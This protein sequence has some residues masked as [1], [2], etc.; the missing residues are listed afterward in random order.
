MQGVKKYLLSKAEHLLIAVIWIIVFILPVLIIGYSGRNDWERVFAIWKRLIPFLIL[1][2]LNHYLLVPFL[3]F[4][5][6]KV[7]YFLVSTIL[8][9]LLSANEFF[10]PKPQISV[11]QKQGRELGFERNDRH[12]P[13]SFRRREALPNNKFPQENLKRI[14]ANHPPGHWPPFISVFLVSVLVL[15]FDTGLIATLKWNEKEKQV[16]KLKS[17]NVFN[18]LAFLRNQI[19]PHFFMNTLNNIHSLIDFDSIAAKESVI[20]LSKLMRYLLYESNDD[21]VFIE[22]EFEFIKSYVSLM[23]LR[24]SEKVDIKL[25]FPETYPQKKVAPMIFTSLIENAFKHGVSYKNAS[26]IHINFVSTNNRVLCEI[27]NSK[28]PSNEKNEFSG[29]GTENTRK[30]LDL[31]YGMNYQMDVIELET[32][33]TVNLTIP[34]E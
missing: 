26:F 20:K 10:K 2:V 3:L 18:Q 32:V 23:Q 33:Y 5:K 1:F 27:S 8:V 14:P 29:V 19:S 25:V 21:K 31:I 30:R 9:L 13:P 6:S 16:I 7:S 17:E 34:L 11:M 22:K 4:G 28:Y 24:Y 15:G 12:H